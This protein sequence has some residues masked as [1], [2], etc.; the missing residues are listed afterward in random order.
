MEKA[1]RILRCWSQL[2]T[3]FPYLSH[4]KKKEIFMANNKPM[5]EEEKKLL[6]RAVRCGIAALEGWEVRL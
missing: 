5:T 2:Q 4:I 1:I 3:L 6:L